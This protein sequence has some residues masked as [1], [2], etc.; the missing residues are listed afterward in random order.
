M[1]WLLDTLWELLGSVGTWVWEYAQD[2][3]VATGL[4]ILAFL[5]AFGTTVQTGTA[6]VLFSFG[7]AK[8]V[9]EPGFHPLIPI[10]QLVR[11]TPIR[12][13]ALDLP[14]QRVTTADGL[15]YDVH[16][17]V[18]YRVADPITA[19]V[20]I[21]DVPQGVLTL[22]PLLVHEL[23]REQTRQTLAARQ[24]LD[25]ELTARVRQALAP[26][27][28]TAE[29]AGMSTVAPTPATVRLT[30]LPARVAERAE[31]LKWQID[32]GVGARVAALLTTAGRAPQGRSA[33][34]YRRHR[35][36]G[37]L[38]TANDELASA[39][40]TVVLPDHAWLKVNEVT[41]SAFGTQVFDT[42]RLEKDRKYVYQMKMTRR[43]YGLD[44][45][46]TRRVEVTAG[47]Q[48]RVDFTQPD[49]ANTLRE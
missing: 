10:F 48:V 31:L 8:K 29:T 42:P 17:K 16:T 37:R 38:S 30:Q 27:G 40:V 4:A 28:V 5:R 13:I 2:H 25:Q 19:A 15:V 49:A 18:V 22:V 26:W 46:E 47:K 23:L 11:H 35:P 33:A 6:G 14:R 43:V 12:S 44:V 7:R 3:P 1:R 34:R 45:S 24:Q 20:A 32:H 39:R 9:L 36:A 41:L 21:D